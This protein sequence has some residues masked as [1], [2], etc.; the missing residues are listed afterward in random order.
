MLN[1]SKCCPE[2]PN[3]PEINDIVGHSENIS[4]K[5]KRPLGKGQCNYAFNW[6]PRSCFLKVPHA[7]SKYTRNQSNTSQA[8]FDMVYRKRNPAFIDLQLY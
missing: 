7:L 5:L 3:G 4:E 8:H 2:Y 6:R 1:K